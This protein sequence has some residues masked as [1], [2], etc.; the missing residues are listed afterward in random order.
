MTLAW[1][2]GRLGGL[3]LLKLG[4]LTVKVAEAHWQNESQ[5]LAA[6]WQCCRGPALRVRLSP[7]DTQVEAGLG[8][9]VTVTV[10]VTV[11]LRLRLGLP[12]SAAAAG[13]P[14]LSHAASLSTRARRGRGLGPA[15]LPTQSVPAV[16]KSLSHWLLHSQHCRNLCCSHISLW[17]LVEIL[18]FHRIIY[19]NLTLVFG[20]Q[21]KS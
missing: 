3:K 12:L 17:N 9:P 14:P 19:S 15:A 13:P 18:A 4:S 11:T 8:M 21:S 16:S 2:L 7:P 10:P 1:P 6:P 20:I 5:R